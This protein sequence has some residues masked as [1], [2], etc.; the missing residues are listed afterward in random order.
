MSK[1]LVV[2]DQS[3]IRT[4]LSNQFKDIEELAVVEAANGN[5]AL[6]KAKVI[7]PNLILLDIVMPNKDGITTLQELKENPSTK[8]IPVIV[9][10]SHGDEEKISKVRELGAERFIDKADMDSIDWVELVKSFL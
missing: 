2:D 10:S 8:D 9:V 5:E 4:K 3:F 7:K 1:V 6:G